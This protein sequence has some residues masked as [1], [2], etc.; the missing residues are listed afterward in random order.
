M[1]FFI[2]RDQINQALKHKDDSLKTIVMEGLS[3]NRSQLLGE[4]QAIIP[5]VDGR[6]RLAL[7]EVLMEDGGRDL[8]PI[9]LYTISIE[10]NILFAK[11][12]I[13]LYG[14]FSYFEAMEQ[15]R[16]LMGKLRS[17]LTPTCQ[18][19]IGKLNAKFRERF[20]MSEF[21]A[22]KQNPKR[23]KHAAGAMVKEPHP[24][25]APFLNEHILSEHQIYRSSG[26]EALA[27]LGD[28]SSIEALFSLLKQVMK[29]RIG[30]QKLLDFLLDEEHLKCGRLLDYLTALGA[31]AGW[32]ASL[33]PALTA[34]VL[35]KKLPTTLA[36]VVHSFGPFPDY[37]WSSA[38]L[39]LKKVLLQG[40]NSPEEAKKLE[41][42]G[43]S[44]M[45]SLTNLSCEISAAIGAIGFR[46]GVSNLFERMGSEIPESDAK[47]DHFLVSFLAAYQSKNAVDTLIGMIHADKDPELL[48]AILDALSH[49]QISE[50]PP[51]ILQ[52][53]RDPE[54]PGI[55]HRAMMLLARWRPE[56]EALGDLLNHES[57]SVRNETAGL[58]AEHG[59]ESGYSQ[60]LACLKPETPR[61][62]LIV[63][64]EAL[65]AFPRAR[66]GEAALPWFL[67]AESYP[68][69]QA[70]LTTLM[71]AGGPS[72]FGYI[73]QALA[74]YPEE[75]L[76]ETLTSVFMLLEPKPGPEQPPDILDHPAFWER[77]LSSPNGKFRMNA[78]TILEKANWGKAS[79][80]QDWLEVFKRS[81]QG[82]AVRWTETEKRRLRGLFLKA[83]ARQTMG[84]TLK[85]DQTSQKR[86]ALTSLIES[87][88]ESSHHDRMAI[89]RK[90]NLRYQPG[91]LPEQDRERLVYQVLNFFEESEGDPIGL[92]LAISIA[93]KMNHDALN[94]ELKKYLNHE[95]KEVGRFARTALHLS[96]IKEGASHIESIFIM[97]HTR[98]MAKTL[99]RFLEKTG[100]DVA[101]A[102]HT[103]EG[104][105]N[106][107]HREYDLLLLEFQLDEMSGVDFLKNARREH[108]A[109][110][111]VIF[112]TTSREDSDHRIMKIAGDG[113]L[114][115]PF[116]MEL[117]HTTIK[118]LETQ[119]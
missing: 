117:M 20:Y 41:A 6:L 65:V 83:R 16:E 19:V 76:A 89:L 4:V 56:E 115:K 43:G 103:T 96:H 92:K 13:L 40:E 54:N 25:Y 94:E 33:A 69:R 51:I 102:H 27:Q 78:L 17:Q 62:F 52:L 75:K 39:Y 105:E 110:A 81:L 60:L 59:L 88:E 53:A 73:V 42:V 10:A 49:Y 11:S 82:E 79:H 116:S 80:F 77:M 24:D 3:Q 108:V 34:E 67:P 2:Y 21:L 84:D 9:F 23:M 114:V 1:D 97:D 63:V 37:F 112:M 15:L 14:H 86:D 106:L 46:K 45:A 32:D 91:I 55:R 29:E 48:K 8:V 47:R 113:L 66:T 98:L 12:M 5:T 38:S 104:M 70:A 35:D 87:V 30:G 72:G 107:A 31:A 18:R 50:T 111:K 26:V 118:S 100:Y 44:Y 85:T 93:G 57:A 119:G 95:D 71:A 22:G 64:L 7:L 68:V 58:I 61:D 101:V 99:K 36:W 90:V 28:L 109:P 74:Q